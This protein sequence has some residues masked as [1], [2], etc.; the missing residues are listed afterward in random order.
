MNEAVGLRQAEEAA[1]FTALPNSARWHLEA[2]TKQGN[3]GAP[4]PTHSVDT[5]SYRARMPE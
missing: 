5:A 2:A 3:C 4:L 1:A